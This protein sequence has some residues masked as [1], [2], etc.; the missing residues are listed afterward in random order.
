MH[1]LYT[2]KGE[3]TTHLWTPKQAESS[4]P[5]SPSPPPPFF[6]LNT[7]AK[8][9]LP[10]FH[11]QVMEW[12]E[13]LSLFFFFL[14]NYFFFRNNLRTKSVTVSNFRFA[15]QNR[16]CFFLGI[17]FLILKGKQGGHRNATRAPPPQTYG[18]IMADLHQNK[19]K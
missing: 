13:F 12:Q 10:L 5:L 1:I 19:K 4:L 7:Q 3:A 11:L 18:A 2:R 16:V 14:K 15:F 17:F 9:V 6:S 8:V